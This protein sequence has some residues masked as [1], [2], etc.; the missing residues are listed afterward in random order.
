MR[1]LLSYAV[2]ALALAG[3]SGCKQKP[4]PETPAAPAT[5]AVDLTALA[6]AVPSTGPRTGNNYKVFFLVLR[7]NQRPASGFKVDMWVKGKSEPKTKATNEA[8]LVQF[9]GLPFPDA[10]HQLMAVLHYYSG[11]TDG[12]RE[13]AYPYIESDA[14]RLKDTQYIPNN[15]TPDPQ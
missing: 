8:G 1:H 10:K 4:A 2:V 6:N 3:L 7:Q 13:I 15:A 12:A 9:D 14:Y 5:K 11:K